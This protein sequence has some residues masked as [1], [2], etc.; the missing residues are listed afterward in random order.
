MEYSILIED[1]QENYKVFHC[2]LI[3]NMYTVPRFEYV[4]YNV[5]HP[6]GVSQ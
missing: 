3:R 4:S 2:S 6:T 1:S 5:A